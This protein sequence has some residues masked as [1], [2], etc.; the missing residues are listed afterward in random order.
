MESLTPL[1][2]RKTAEQMGLLTINFDNFKRINNVNSELNILSDFPKPFDGELGILPGGAESNGTVRLVIDEDSNPS[3]RPARRIAV[4]LKSKVKDKLESM[5]EKRVLAKVDQPTDWVS[6]MA[7]STKKSGDIRVCIDPQ[8]LNKCLKREHFQLLLM[9]DV[10]PELSKGKIFSKLDLADGYWHCVLDEESS[11]MTTMNT[12][13]GRY[14]WLRLPFGLS[15]SSEIFQKRL[16]MALDGIDGVMCVADDIIVWGV[17]E[18]DHDA[19]IDHDRKLKLVLQKCSDDGIKL[20]KMKCE[21]RKT[22]LEFLGPVLSADGL[23]SDPSKVSAVKDLKV[24]NNV[25][26]VQRL[27]GLVNYLSK[28]MPNLSEVMEPIW[29]FTRKDVPWDWT[30]VHD[31]AF[32]KIKTMIT[33]APVLAYYDPKSTLVLQCDASQSGLGAALLQNGH[34]ITYASRALTDTEKRYAQIE[35]EALSIVFGLNKFHQYTFGHLTEVHN[36]HRP[37]KAI[38]KKPLFKAPKRLQGMLLRILEYD[39]KIIWK[40]GKDMLVADLQSRAYQPGD[41]EEF[42]FASINMVSFLPIGEARLTKIQQHTADDDV[43]C[44]LKNAIFSG[45]PEAREDVPS[46]VMPYFHI[47]DELS[48]QGG[49]IFRGERVVVPRSLRPEFM[50]QLH[51]SNLGINSCFGRARECLFWPGMSAE[52]RMKIETCEAWREFDTKQCKEPLMPHEVPDRPWAKIGCDLITCEGKEY[53]VT[54]DYFSNYWEID[55]LGTT[56]SASKV[57]NKLKAHFARHG[58]PETVV[59]DNGPQFDSEEFA[60]FSQK[61]DFEHTTSSP[62]HSRANGLTESAVKAAE[63]L[64]EKT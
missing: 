54:A 25:E 51:S 36:D 12:P 52:V 16:M 38:S 42:E 1:L 18:N 39:T 30:E 44:A 15:V 46:M 33:E 48:V 4:A 20:N 29:N 53:L 21:F 34:P 14:R 22:E 58:I 47:R 13:F 6:Q 43:L 7:I 27:N 49:I 45:W 31:Q 57:I 35:K 5:V 62:H 17:G 63:R 37:L 8:D 41:G 11:Y 50:D 10:L 9:E 61:W 2:S 60:D 59:S 28:F 19:V 23:K 24:P 64:L 40:P 32:N 56:K 3:V 26:E 55:C